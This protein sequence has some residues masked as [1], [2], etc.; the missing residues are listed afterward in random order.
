MHLSGTPTLPRFF[1]DP[2]H[3]I[4]KKMSKYTDK[5]HKFDRV[6]IDSICLENNCSRNVLYLTIS[7]LKKETQTQF[8]AL[9]KLANCKS[10]FLFIFIFV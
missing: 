8:L 1:P 9:G 6:S 3:F 4:V 5:W 10:D 7:K 2:K